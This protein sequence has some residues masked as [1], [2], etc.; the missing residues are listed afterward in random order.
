M[1]SP[2]ARRKRPVG[3]DRTRH[4]F[5]DEAGFLAFPLR[6]VKKSMKPTSALGP[7][8]LSPDSVLVEKSK[9]AEGSGLDIQ[10]VTFSNIDLRRFL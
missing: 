7:P 2:L 5:S 4:T 10:Q 9:E 1:R 3:G 8:P 6:C